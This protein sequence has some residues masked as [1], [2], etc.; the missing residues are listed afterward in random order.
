M[1]AANC[2]VLG[3]ELAVRKK[4]MTETASE[5]DEKV[6]SAAVEAFINEELL[7]VTESKFQAI[8]ASEA[9]SPESQVEGPYQDSYQRTE[10]ACMHPLVEDNA[11]LAR[12]FAAY[13]HTT[14]FTNRRTS[15]LL[16][17]GDVYRKCLFV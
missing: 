14:L 8:L 17:L 2:E 12:S 5:F 9:S 6:L 4:F 7:P 11:F 13:E 1:L 3:V 10:L 16:F 15:F